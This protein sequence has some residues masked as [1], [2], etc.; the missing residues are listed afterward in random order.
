MITTN[1]VNANPLRQIKGKVELFNGSTLQETLLPDGKLQEITVARTCE[2]GKFFGF[3]ICQQATVKVIDQSGSTICTKG[4][5]L[6][7]YF[8][9]DGSNTYSLVCPSFYIK[10]AQKDETTNIITITAYDALDDAVGHV[11]NEIGLYAPYTLKQLVE[12]IARFLGLSVNITDS[13]FDLSYD[14]GANF[15]GDETLRSV[16]NAVAEVT[17]T[18]YFVNHQDQLIFKRLAN[19]DAVVETIDKNTYFNLTT[20]LPVTITKI[21]H[22]TELGDNIEHGTTDGE[23]QYI[24][25]NPFWNTRADLDTL[26]PAALNRISG[27]TIVP[28]ALK[29]RGDYFTEIGDKIKFAD[30]DGSYVESFILDDTISYTGGM[31]QNTKW[32]YSPDNSRNTA[33]NP[34]TIG[35]KL[36]QTFAKVDKIEKNITL[37]VGEVITEELPGMVEDAINGVTDGLVVDINGLKNTT[38]TNT[39]NIASLTLTTQAINSEVSS[40]KESTTTIT[41]ELNEVVSSQTTLQKDLAT[42]QTASNQ[43]S[44]SVSSLEQLTLDNIDTVS[45]QIS[46]LQQQADLVITS[47]DVA[48]QISQALEDGVSEVKTSTGYVF[49]DTG[50]HIDKSDSEMNSTLNEKGLTVRRQDTSVLDANADGVN[51][52]NVKIRQ[53]LNIGGSRFQGYNGNRVGCFWIGD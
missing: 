44:A 5:K 15:A 27:L 6:K 25:D 2:H 28:F 49:N 48:I 46:S 16:L 32:E 12:A 41:N 23:C 11:I 53:Y 1:N 17:Q 29:W 51:A 34:A 14:K 24:R 31:V 13:A 47:E 22:V 40:I 26:I 33:A 35:E 9:A 30:K 50:L 42:L 21:V 10:D 39:E 18:I 37:Y 36:N 3:G 52:L 7:T 38:K 43:I 20:A 8:N 4:R 45:S 19:A